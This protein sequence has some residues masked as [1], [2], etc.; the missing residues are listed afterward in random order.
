MILL[1]RIVLYR[2][3]LYLIF[4]VLIDIND[5]DKILVIPLRLAI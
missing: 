2:E 4:S 1:N 5:V 3:V